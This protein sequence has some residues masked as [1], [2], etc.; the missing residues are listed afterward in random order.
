V[1]SVYAFLLDLI[2]LTKKDVRDMKWIHYWT[3]SPSLQCRNKTM[4]YIVSDCK[5]LFGV[6]ATWNYFEAGHGK[7]PCD[8]LGGTSEKMIDIAVRQHKCNIQ[9]AGD[10]PMDRNISYK[11]KV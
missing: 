11:Y 3:D 5:E 9:D 1:G 4:F 6:P 2:P 8:G 10:F 7:G